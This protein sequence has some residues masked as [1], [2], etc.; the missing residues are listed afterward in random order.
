MCVRER[1]RERERSL[2]SR[3]VH[4][5]ALALFHPSFALMD[6]LHCGYMYNNDQITCKR[7]SDPNID[8][9]MASKVRIRRV[10]KVNNKNR[11]RKN[12]QQKAKQQQQ[13]NTEERDNKAQ[14]IR[15][16]RN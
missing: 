8:K 3:A 10:G 14:K 2:F 4:Q 9:S 13:K 6:G 1:E 7:K 5:Q 15:K 12:K 16:K 11:E